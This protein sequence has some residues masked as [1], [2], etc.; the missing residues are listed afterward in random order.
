MD[1]Q[2]Q[3]FY[4]IAGARAYL[5]TLT[6]EIM[7][8]RQFVRQL[9][10]YAK[11][12]SP[13]MLCIR[14]E[15]D[16]GVRLAVKDSSD[17]R[18]EEA[19]LRVQGV[20]CKAHLPPKRKLLRGEPDAV[21]F[22]QQSFTLVGCDSGIFESAVEGAFA[23][24]EYLSRQDSDLAP[25]RPS[26]NGTNIAIEASNRLFVKQNKQGSHVPVAMDA[27]VDP[28][29]TLQKMA[30]GQYIHTED[31]VVRYFKREL[32]AD[33]TIRYNKADS[34]LFKIGDIVEAQCSFI[35]I[36]TRGGQHTMKIILRAM[37]MLNSEFSKDARLALWK[38]K[39]LTPGNSTSPQ[40]KTSLRRTVG[41]EA[42]GEVDDEVEYVN[43]KVKTMQVDTFN[44]GNATGK[45]DLNKA[46]AAIRCTYDRAST[47]APPAPL[48]GVYVI[49]GISGPIRARI[50]INR[51]IPPRCD[52]N[53]IMYFRISALPASHPLTMGPKAKRMTFHDIPRGGHLQASKASTCFSVYD[54]TDIII[55]DF[56]AA[57][58][59][60]FQYTCKSTCRAVRAFKQIAFHPDRLL[61]HFF[62]HPELFRLM[63]ART[64]SVLGGAAA[65]SFFA[66]TT[67]E[68]TE[69]ELFVNPGH[70]YE[71]ARH[72][73]DT[74]GYSFMPYGTATPQEFKHGSK[75]GDSDRV[76][77]QHYQE[78]VYAIRAIDNIFRFVKDEDSSDPQVVFVIMT[79]RCALHTILNSH[80]TA[81]MNIISHDMAVSF[82]PR[83]TF[84]QN[85]NQEL[86]WNMLHR[87][88]ESEHAMSEYESK[89]FT[90]VSWRNRGEARALFMTGRSR[91][92]GDEHCWTISFKSPTPESTNALSKT[93][94]PV[95]RNLLYENTWKM[96]G[97]GS[98]M[99]MKFCVVSLPIFRYS[100]TVSE[101]SDAAAMRDFYE[102]Q[103][104]L[105]KA[106]K[107]RDALHQT[108]WDGKVQDIQNGTADNEDYQL[109]TND[110]TYADGAGSEEELLYD[111]YCDGEET[112]S[113]ITERSYFDVHPVLINSRMKRKTIK[114]ILNHYRSANEDRG[115]GE[116]HT[117]T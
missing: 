80:S 66:R 32:A 60:N 20:I 117:H 88:D 104:Q 77:A 107:S 73:I 64:G 71:V 13:E 111:A 15:D 37:T 23:I 76:E 93:S 18:I 46:L 91:R 53:D 103:W 3:E 65:L 63:Q 57:D 42:D 97:A 110:Q 86:F 114:E 115:G 50:Y 43:K 102:D 72:L 74:Q 33:G 52:W 101:D 30:N 78:S 70:G 6:E 21:R 12:L 28:H 116:V 79:T 105:E 39:V 113:T 108:W 9:A 29:A 14:S 1:N 19:V 5:E 49:A 36:P 54:I 96:V 75:E 62:A 25:W 55:T 109:Q 61:C 31:C 22:M 10:A 90:K 48:S 8:G 85:E 58:M 4:D 87:R 69:M 34:S 16:E 17:G 44:P 59:V 47:L 56:S 82:Y 11:D 100:Y 41:Y 89:G 27:S 94:P 106:A 35:V 83:A 2:L 51:V 84:L 40:P 38:S 26:Q 98:F 92:V 24:S 99:Q 7:N 81:S 95:T 68:E 67:H 112:E 45:W